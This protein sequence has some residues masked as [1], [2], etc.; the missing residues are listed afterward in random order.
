MIDE[1]GACAASSSSRA[2]S[3]SRRRISGSR[4]ADARAGA[5][6]VP[7]CRSAARRSQRLG[8]VERGVLVAL[9]A[10]HVE[11][12]HHLVHEVAHVLDERRVGIEV[13]G[14]PE[15]GQHLLAEAVGGGDGGGV[16]VGQR[17]PQPGAAQR[18]L[19]AARQPAARRRRRR[20][21]PASPASARSTAT[22]RSRTRSRSSPVAMRV[23]VTSRSCSSGVP[24]AT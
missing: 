4:A 5:I 14:H 13:A 24:S 15:P 20:E 16:E 6:G 1:R 22:S 19:A 12:V 3:A 9:E 23:N 10:P 18:R 2:A 21:S 7:G 8:A 11:V 17:A